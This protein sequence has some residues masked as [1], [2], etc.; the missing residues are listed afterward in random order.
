[1]AVYAVF[2]SI[3]FFYNFD[4]HPNAQQNSPKYSSSANYT[5]N[6]LD[7]VKDGPIKSSAPFLHTFRLNKHFHQADISPCSVFSVKAQPPHVIPMTF[8]YYPEPFAPS[9][10]PIARLL[11]GPPFAA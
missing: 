5:G 8:F 2:F 10:V 3:Q 7:A 4:G 9:F 11:R 6:G 1:M